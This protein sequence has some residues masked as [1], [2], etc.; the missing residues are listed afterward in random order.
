VLSPIVLQGARVRLELLDPAHVADLAAAAAVDRSSFGFTRV[1]D[2]RPATGD[3]VEVAREEWRA[4]G[5]LPFA[6][7]DRSRGVAVGST[8]FTD[9]GV[10]PE[11]GAPSD[12]NPPNVSEIGHTWYGAEAQRTGINIE[13]KLL[14]LTQ[15]FDVWPGIRVTFKTDARN[16]RSA[17]A[18]ERLGARFEGV[19]RAHRPAE[20]GSI[21]DSAYFSVLADEWPG[22]RAGLLDRLARG[23]SAPGGHGAPG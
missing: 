5:C 19:R 15:A 9:W 11:D 17:H 13:A 18:I 4:G 3:W 20:D 10:L 2:G 16:Q 1:P 14:L 22:V 8:R 12:T 6:V 21:R 7:I 23:G